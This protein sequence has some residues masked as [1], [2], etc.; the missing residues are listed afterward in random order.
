MPRVLVST[1]P[2]RSAFVRPLDQRV[3][4]ASGGSAAVKLTPARVG[5][6]TLTVDIADAQG[7]TVDART[8]TATL[9]LPADQYGP[10]NVPLQRAGTGRYSSSA[11][12]LTKAGSWEL[13]I[14]VQVSEFDRDV[15]EVDFK[16]N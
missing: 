1:A 11:V 2:A 6:N 4:L 7:R 15:A 14:R 12:S 3:A 9:A 8:V 5:T 13:V 16:V 10:L